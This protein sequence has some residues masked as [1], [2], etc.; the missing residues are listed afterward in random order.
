MNPLCI[1]R[2]SNNR[3]PILLCHLRWHQ[4][5][6]SACV[7]DEAVPVAS[8]PAFYFK[9]TGM[10]DPHR[11]GV[12]TASLGNLNNC[13]RVFPRNREVNPLMPAIDDGV[14][15]LQDVQPDYSIHRYSM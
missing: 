12:I 4:G 2:C 11:H 15:P 13:S 3:N 6:E 10:G 8:D 14:V 5:G 1:D 7:N 9:S